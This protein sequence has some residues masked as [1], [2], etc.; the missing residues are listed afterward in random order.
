ML[1]LALRQIVDEEDGYAGAQRGM[2]KDL[3]KGY[4]LGTH[5]K[6]NLTRDDIHER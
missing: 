3:Q 2:L 5:G 1:T 4:N 6:I